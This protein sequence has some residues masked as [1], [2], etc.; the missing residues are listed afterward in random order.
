MKS[1]LNLVF[2]TLIAVLSIG[3]PITNYAATPPIQLD[4]A[5]QEIAKYPLIEPYYS[6]VSILVWANAAAVSAYRYS[7]VNYQKEWQ[8]TATYFSPKGWQHFT[9][10]M[11]SNLS[12]VIKKKLVVSAVATGTPIILSKGVLKNQYTWQIQM[13]LLITYQNANEYH[14]QH[15]IVSLLISRIPN[16]VRPHGIAIEQFVAKSFQPPHS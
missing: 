12:H 8:E 16:Q 2:S 3:L 15:V 6:D 5:T 13:P 9:K 7:F 10:A 1:P 11:Q 14:Q 4:C